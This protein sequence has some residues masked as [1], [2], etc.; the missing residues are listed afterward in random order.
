MAVRPAPDVHHLYYAYYIPESNP[1]F[2]TDAPDPDSS[3]AP[4]WV[5]NIGNHQPLELMTFI[6]TIERTLGI[7]VKKNFLPMHVDRDWDRQLGK[8]VSEPQEN[9]RLPQF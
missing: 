5:Y 4:Y 8:L 6:Q 7:E 3:Y 9:T 2:D 1:A